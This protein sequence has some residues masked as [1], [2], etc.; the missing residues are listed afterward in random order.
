MTEKI[1]LILMVILAALALTTPVLRRSVIFLGMYSL[2]N[3][4]VYLLYRAPD[5]AIAEAIIG[6]GISTVL[7]LVVLK[8]YQVF[9]IYYVNR[10]LEEL[11][12]QSITGQRAQLIRELENFLD[13]QD[14]EAH[15]VYTAE[16][17]EDLLEDRNFDLLIDQQAEKV[18]FYGFAADYHM[19]E[20]EK[21]VREKAYS[22]LEIH[23][24]RED[25]TNE[26]Q[27]ALSE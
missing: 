20:V 1:V 12:D 26:T 9:K 8:K 25:G 14:L 27:Y 10:E 13:G 17:P 19:D 3:S 16:D 15:I 6:C 5:V 11:D 22:N 18:V 24:I 23:R 2:I 7:Y 21:F 4:F